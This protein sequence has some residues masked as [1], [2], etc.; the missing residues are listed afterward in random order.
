MMRKILVTMQEK[1]LK[2]R[3][4]RCLLHLL[5]SLSSIGSL[6]QATLAHIST[7]CSKDFRPTLIPAFRE[8]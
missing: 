3:Q 5:L 1:L 7:I 6:V 2:L 8:S 4:S